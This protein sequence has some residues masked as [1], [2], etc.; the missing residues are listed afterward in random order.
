MAERL[1]EIRTIEKDG[2]FLAHIRADWNGGPWIELTFWDKEDGD[3]PYQP[4][5]EY[6]V[7]DYEMQAPFIPFTQES[8]AAALDNW[9][10]RW[11]R[12]YGAGALGAWLKAYLEHRRG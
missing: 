4:I 8:L 3:I 10:G 11:D 7:W 12:S 2:R 6:F 9:V 1:T 5:H